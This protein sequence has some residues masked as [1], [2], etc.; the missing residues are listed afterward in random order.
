MFEPTIS[1]LAKK[2]NITVDEN[3]TVKQTANEI[4]E[5]LTLNNLL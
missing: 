3:I 4:S 5:Y 1:L 2:Q